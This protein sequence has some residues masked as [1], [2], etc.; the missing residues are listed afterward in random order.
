MPVGGSFS[1]TALVTNAGARSRFANIFAGLVMA[2][3]I[4]LFGSSIGYV[5]MPSMAGLLIVIGF[6]TFKPD[7]VEM[8]WKTGLV[9]Q[10]VMGI[11]FVACLLISLQYAVLIYAWRTGQ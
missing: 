7:R 1:A 5:A 9:Q 11:T 2:V 10:V 8:V 4:V 6:R 3:V